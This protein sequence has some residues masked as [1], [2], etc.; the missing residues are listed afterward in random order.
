MRTKRA[1]AVLMM[2]LVM[3][4]CAP[5][6]I[7]AEQKTVTVTVTD[8][9]GLA[10]VF[11]DPLE[12]GVTAVIINL[13]GDSMSADSVVT[14]NTQAGITYT[15]KGATSDSYSFTAPIKITGDGT[16]VIDNVYI[17]ASATSVDQA[18]WVG[19]K[20]NV[21]V[22]ANIIGG[23]N[24]TYVLWTQDQ[25]KVTINGSIIDNRPAGENP[26]ADT[27]RFGVA[28]SGG[29]ATQSGS[30]VVIN[31]AVKVTDNGISASGYSSVEVKSVEA[32]LANA[33]NAKDNATVKV[34]GTAGQDVVKGKTDG[35]VAQ[36]DSKVTVT[37]GNV[38]GNTGRG[39][40]ADN[41]SVVKVPGNVSGKTVG[42]EAKDSSTVEVEGDVNGADAE[43]KGERVLNGGSGIKAENSANVK[44]TG[45]VRGGKSFGDGAEGGDGIVASD[46]SK[47]EVTKDVTAGES[48]GTEAEG[49][50]GIVASGNA[51]VKVLGSVLGGNCY[52]MPG[53]SPVGCS[54][55]YGI[56]MSDYPTISVGGD[57]YGGSMGNSAGE[58]G[59]GGHGVYIEAADNSNETSSLTVKGAIGGGTGGNGAGSVSGDGIRIVFRTPSEAKEKWTTDDVPSVTLW[60]LQAGSST[61][62]NAIY[63]HAAAGINKPGA[64]D[65]NK[66]FNYIIRTES[67]ENGTL[68]AAETGN[69]GKSVK[70]NV[71]PNSGYVVSAVEADAG[72]IVQSGNQFSIKMPTYGGVNVV[73]RFEEGD[74]TPVTPVTPS[75]TAAG[76]S[77]GDDSSITLWVVLVLVC[78]AAIITFVIIDRKKKK[79]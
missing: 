26:T 3:M 78:A 16:V 43:A 68:S 18:L 71:T 20:A 32:Q 64:E 8:A 11:T 52:Q 1:I 50:E 34:N 75:K 13:S 7:T 27:S 25:A 49:G 9:T 61:S 6:V 63:V 37:A 58:S 17:N 39:V 42:V 59:D 21:T 48:Y 31:G 62:G 54:A 46:D 4:A 15:I 66:T 35:I 57:V 36:N 51:N 22:N 29:N 28:A 67:G 74:E 38:I 12:E 44:V 77:T 10:K 23:A 60:K 14:L 73:A 47:V 69:A 79:S 53:T 33:V 55:G 5:G 72:E 76:P 24:Q 30:S 56:R 41:N 19:D 65:V 70:L 45:N 40:A 2:L